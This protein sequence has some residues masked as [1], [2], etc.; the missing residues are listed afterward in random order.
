M[1]KTVSE[2]ASDLGVGKS[3]IIHAIK[4]SGISPAGVAVKQPGQRG[5]PG[6]TY[7]VAVVKSAV[8]AIVD[9]GKGRPR[10]A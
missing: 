6:A 7:D 2:L 9:S 8:K 5:K 3:T 10:K 4:K 1:S